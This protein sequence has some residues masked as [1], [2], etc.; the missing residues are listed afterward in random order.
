VLVMP[1]GSGNENSWVKDFKVRAGNR[2][3]RQRGC[4]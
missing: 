3:R 4:G 2:E 1:W